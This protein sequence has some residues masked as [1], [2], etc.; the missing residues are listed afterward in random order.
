MAK[1]SNDMQKGCLRLSVIYFNNNQSGREPC[2][3]AQGL[4]LYKD[5]R[6]LLEWEVRELSVF[7]AARQGKGGL[8]TD[9]VRKPLVFT[10]FCGVLAREAPDIFHADSIPSSGFTRVHLRLPFIIK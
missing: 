9:T 5:T 8:D 1:N 7:H 4:P 3:H 2:L 10:L 6:W